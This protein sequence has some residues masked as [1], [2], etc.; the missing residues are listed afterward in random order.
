MVIPETV[1]IAED[2]LFITPL[3][4]PEIFC[5]IYPTILPSASEELLPFKVAMAPGVYTV[6]S[7]P[8][9]ETGN[10]FTGKLLS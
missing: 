1:A 8:A 7:L 9:F 10:I 5:Q 4:G 2:A 6:L 3:E